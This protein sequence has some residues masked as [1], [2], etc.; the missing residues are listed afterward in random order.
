MKRWFGPRGY[1]TGLVPVSWQGWLLTAA[2][3]AASAAQ[4]LTPGLND[5]QHFSAEA[6]IV[7]VYLG[8][9]VLTRGPDPR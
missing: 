7:L 2:L 8:I 5:I 4:G 3:V 9:G 6:A 1:S